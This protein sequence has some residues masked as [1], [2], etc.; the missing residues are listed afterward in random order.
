MTE[1]CVRL[2]QTS[3]DS[4]KE[5]SSATSASDS[6]SRR[7]YGRCSFNKTNADACPRYVYIFFKLCLLNISGASS[8]NAIGGSARGRSFTRVECC[9]PGSVGPTLR[10]RRR[11][12]SSPLE[13]GV[14]LDVAKPSSPGLSARGAG[15]GGEANVSV[16]N[17]TIESRRWRWRLI[18]T[19]APSRLSR[20]TRWLRRRTGVHGS[21]PA[22]SFATGQAGLRKPQRRLRDVCRGRRLRARHHDEARAE[23][24]RGG[25]GHSSRGRRRQRGFLW[26]GGR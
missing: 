8:A 16:A 22:G 2:F 17:V 11:S 13:R 7:R 12:L 14:L 4:L 9:C 21:P 1:A 25:Q 26:W 18:P 24:D 15:E 5:G 20:R 6:R 10:A 19:S 23:R 3:G